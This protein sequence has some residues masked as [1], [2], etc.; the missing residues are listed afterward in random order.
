MVA[1]LVTVAWTLTK[2]TALASVI[3]S[4]ALEGQ[5]K[6]STTP[7][8]SQ[9]D[10]MVRK[11]QDAL[12]VFAVDMQGKTTQASFQTKDLGTGQAE[13]LGEG[14]SLEIRDGRFT[15]QFEPWAVHIYKIV[16]SSS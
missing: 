10:T 13:V 1:A 5:L 16:P 8:A 2:R 15:D 3:N 4:P 7:K 11:T 12:Y 14:R 9:V 6:I